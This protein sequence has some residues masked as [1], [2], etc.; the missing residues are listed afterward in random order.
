MSRRTTDSLLNLGLN[1]PNPLVR[2]MR[3][4]G[5]SSSLMPPQKVRRQRGGGFREQEAAGHIRRGG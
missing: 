1:N 4:K 2:A 5:L 3:L